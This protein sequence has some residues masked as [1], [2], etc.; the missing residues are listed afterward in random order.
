MKVK[1]Y[2]LIAIVVLAPLMGVQAQI[3]D[4]PLINSVLFVPYAEMSDSLIN[5]Q[6]GYKSIPIANIIQSSL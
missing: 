2:Y 4:D 6:E 5:C 3:Y 1:L